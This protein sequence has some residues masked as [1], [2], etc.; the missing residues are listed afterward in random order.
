MVGWLGGRCGACDTYIQQ[1]AASV[2]MLYMCHFNYSNF[3]FVC[4]RLVHRQQ[5]FATN[6]M[7]FRSHNDMINVPM[8]TIATWHIPNIVPERTFFH[9]FLFSSI[10]CCWTNK[11]YL[12]WKYNNR[13]CWLKSP[14]SLSLFMSLDDIFTFWI[15]SY[16]VMCLFFHSSFSMIA[17]FSKI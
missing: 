12:N 7:W 13:V 14:S 4:S 2:Y 5:L 3:S 16:I 17:R 1:S 9:V 6:T 8:V 10:L 15:Y 11:V